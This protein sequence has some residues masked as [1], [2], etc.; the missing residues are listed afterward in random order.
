MRSQICSTLILL[1]L[2]TCAIAGE[3][4]KTE[5]KEDGMLRNGP[6][7]KGTRGGSRWRQRE[8]EE[9][10]DDQEEVGGRNT[11]LSF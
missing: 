11:C 9:G 10:E 7:Y 6:R 8:E 1:L 4:R 5:E 3:E 2:A